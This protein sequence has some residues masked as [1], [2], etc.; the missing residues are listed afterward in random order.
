[1]DELRSKLKEMQSEHQC[2]DSEAKRY[3]D[4]YESEQKLRERLTNRFDRVNDHT[5]FQT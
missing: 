5:N 1:M 4:L 2:K 3:K